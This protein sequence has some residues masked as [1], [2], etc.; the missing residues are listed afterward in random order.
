MKATFRARG[1]LGF[2]QGL[3]PTYFKIIPATGIAFFIND[4][5]KNTLLH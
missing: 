5:M 2:Y 3:A 1:I 4:L